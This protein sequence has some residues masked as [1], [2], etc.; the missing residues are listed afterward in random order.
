[1][2]ALVEIESGAAKEE[3]ALIEFCR[4]QLARYKVP[5]RILIVERIV[6][7]A[8]GKPDRRAATA[9]LESAL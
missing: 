7:N 9:R 3:D 1:V 2:Q 6:R 8:M 4:T 5:K